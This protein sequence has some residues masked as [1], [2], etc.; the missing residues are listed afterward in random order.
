MR[1]LLFAGLLAACVSGVHVVS[2]GPV[3]SPLARDAVADVT[4]NTSVQKVYWACRYGRCFWVRP[5]RR[6]VV[7]R[8]W[9]RWYGGPLICRWY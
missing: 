5:Y 4:A 2:A 9:R 8:C 3:A 1:G 7:R 6:I